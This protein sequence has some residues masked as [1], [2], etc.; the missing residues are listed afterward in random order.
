MG[1]ISKARKKKMFNNTK[2]A[3]QGLE[4]S[5]KAM[6]FIKSGDITEL[7]SLSKPPQHVCD[8]LQVVMKTIYRIKPRIVIENGEK[9][10][11]YWFVTKKFLAA[12]DFLSRV[13]AYQD[14]K[15]VAI[16]NLKSF[17]ENP[18]FSYEKIKKC[19]ASAGSFV[20][21]LKGL[22]AFNRVRAYFETLKQTDPASYVEFS[23]K[24]TKKPQRKSSKDSTLS[25]KLKSTDFR[26]QI[27]RIVTND[28]DHGHPMVR[29]ELA[30]Q[31][32]LHITKYDILELRSFKNP[33]Q[34]VFN[35]L[36]V[37]GII[38]GERTYVVQQMMSE[39]QL[40]AARLVGFNKDKGL[41]S[42]KMR[43]LENLIENNLNYTAE[44]AKKVSAALENIVKWTIG[45][46]QY[47]KANR[48]MGMERSSTTLTRYPRQ[49]KSY[50][51]FRA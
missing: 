6:S 16:E 1:F 37:V 24:I 15:P 42:K 14:I 20:A 38:L 12:P 36:N 27:P 32:T 4:D 19:S 28:F 25:Y 33:P 23:Q 30:R 41:S 21:W 3:F 46:Y 47:I 2:D 40:F 48:L 18:E 26:H 49:F 31:Y 51:D 39:P 35:A 50:R 17:L 13:Q 34:M 5:I 45:V 29:R 7:K 44:N 22:Y 10:E 8:V 43:I 11:D 9:R